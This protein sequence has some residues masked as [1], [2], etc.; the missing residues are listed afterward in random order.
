M[1]LYGASG[2]GKVIKEIA[3]TR[4]LRVEGFI[5]DN[6]AM[7]ELQGLPVLHSTEGVDE[8]LI[9]IGENHLRK[10]VAE[11]NSCPIAEALVHSLAIASSSAT[12]DKGT[13]VMAGAIIN[14]ETKIG[15]HCIINTGASIDHECQIADF[16]HISPHAT[17]CGHVNVGEGTWIGA[18]TVIIPGIH[19]GSWSVIGAGSVVVEDIP[20]GVIAFGNPC[21]VIK[22]INQQQN[23]NY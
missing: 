1:F 9:S 23:N 14:T 3:E 7:N 5:D 12:I 21:R 11:K 2:H 15:K 6:P 17:L 8:I 16:A 10:K 18:G 19:I 4:G 20:D 22:I 13:V